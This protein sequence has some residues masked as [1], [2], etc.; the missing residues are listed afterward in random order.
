MQI[1]KM[2]LYYSICE[3]LAK[4]V[5]KYRYGTSLKRMNDVI[6]FQAFCFF[7]LAAIFDSH[8]FRLVILVLLPV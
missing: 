6:T 2:K 1:L 3:P 5:L 7:K 8:L 4:Y